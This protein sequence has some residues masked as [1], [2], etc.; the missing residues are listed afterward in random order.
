MNTSA[1][2]IV[3]EVCSDANLLA[4]QSQSHNYLDEYSS[5]SAA[6]KTRPESAMLEVAHLEYQYALF[7]L[8]SG[9]YRHAFMSLRLTMELALSGIFYSAE[10]I[11]Y[12]R[13]VAGSADINWGAVIDNEEG[14]FSKNFI[15]AFSPEFAENGAQYRAIAAASYR[16]CSEYVH[17]NWKTHEQAGSHVKLKEE[18][19]IAWH[20]LADSVHLAITFA[21]AARFGSYLGTDDLSSVQPIL[22]DAIGELPAVQALF[23]AAK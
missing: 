4:R 8:A 17:G 7:A 22:T 9:L 16:E 23:G 13:W 2:T 20:E 1:A 10:E 19:F 3:E 11:R 15:K 21:F 18:L 5:F 12:R 6:I 14:L